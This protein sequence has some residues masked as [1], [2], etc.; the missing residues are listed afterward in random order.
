MVPLKEKLKTMKKHLF[1]IIAFVLLTGSVTAQDKKASALLTTAIYEEEVT[2]NLDK[3]VALYL[4]ILKEYPDDRPVA[5][6]TLYHLGLVN[7][8]MG[9]QKATEYFTRLVNSYP[10][11]TAI[12]AQA[13]VRLAVLG[14][15]PGRTAT[16][17]LTVRRLLPALEV[18][19]TGAP[20][21][22]GRYLSISDPESGDLAVLEIGT[23][24]KR[25]LTNKGS[26]SSAEGVITSRWS[27]DGKKIACLW[28]NKDMAPE[29]RIIEISGGGSK[30]LVPG[31]WVMDWSPDGK[32]LLGRA[33]GRNGSFDLVLSS[34]AD[35][36]L[37]ILKPAQSIFRAA[38]SPDGRYVV[39]ELPQQN[40][41]PPYDLSLLSID[42]KSDIPLVK[43]PSND[44][45]LGWVPGTE[46]VLFTSD[47][48]GTK[49][50]W[51]L[52][53]VNGQPQGDPMLVKQDIGQAS[54]MGFTTDGSFYYSVMRSIVE[55][56]EVSLDPEKGEIT[57]SPKKIF[58]RVVGTN[59]TPEWS[60]DGKYLAY[61][62]ERKTGS[63]EQNPYILCIRSEQTGEE[64]EVPLTIKSFW[65]MHWSAGSDAVFATMTDNANQGLFRIDIQS[66]RQTLVAKSVPES[67]IKNFAVSPDGK[68]VYYVLFQWTK[69]LVTI[70]WH[71]L[72]TGQEKELYRKEAP[73]DIGSTM[74]SPDG[75]YVSF[76]TSDFPLDFVLR[77][78]PVA[79]GETRD[80]LKSKLG[81]FTY[82]VWTP[83]GKTILFGRRADDTKEDIDGLW[84]VPSE[85]GEPRKIEIKMDMN[86]LRLHPDGR[87]IAFISGKTT[88]ELWVL[89][90]FL[91]K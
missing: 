65:G 11:Q 82:Q 9:R 89:E 20:S 32:Y 39:Y 49:D 28:L 22:D 21:P 86:D 70:I 56:Y 13:R 25:R 58:E 37:N 42:G 36:S 1:L 14:G 5:A 76:I 15:V 84:Q 8:K 7:E 71:D 59:Y 43:H 68:S 57:G 16:T 60:P 67:L 27:P 73:P 91:P 44:R 19:A 53:V 75:K 55:A 81:S 79:G 10:D 66:G 52:R 17:G 45:L 69:K 85:G 77:I 4:D 6:K 47:R 30:T 48:T 88:N 38:F 72:E 26:W 64:R 63:A 40:D 51:A 24:Q 41:S 61:V 33:P 78:V 3:A 46:F 23:G 74:V 90:N 50:A 62:A 54:P 18:D 34:V 12:V 35:G 87:R 80:M 29:L 2:G 83:D 31:S